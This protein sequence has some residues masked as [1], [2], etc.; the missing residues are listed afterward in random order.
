MKII[1]LTTGCQRKLLEMREQYAD[2][3]QL[4]GEARDRLVARALR[5]FVTENNPAEWRKAIL[6]S[7]GVPV[8]VLDRP[9]YFIRVPRDGDSKPTCQ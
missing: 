7:N 3:M 8:L 9:I 2:I 6:D 5:S 4:K 1:H